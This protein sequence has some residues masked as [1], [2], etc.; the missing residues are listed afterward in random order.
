LRKKLGKVF[1]M[2]HVFFHP[3]NC[4][5]CEIKNWKSLLGH[6]VL[7]RIPIFRT[8]TKFGFGSFGVKPKKPQAKIFV[9]THSWYLCTDSFNYNHIQFPLHIVLYFQRWYKFGNI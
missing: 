8:F 4:Y 9:N 3:K 7:P 6:G 5:F 2:E 1:S